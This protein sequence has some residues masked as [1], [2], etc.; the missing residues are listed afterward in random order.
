MVGNLLRAILYLFNQI[1]QLGRITVSQPA[2]KQASKTAGRPAGRPA[3]RRPIIGRLWQTRFGI[4]CP[5]SISS[6]YHLARSCS[7][8]GFGELVYSGDALCAAFIPALYIL[9]EKL[10][11]H[12]CVLRKTTSCLLPFA[13]PGKI[14][15]A[16]RFVPQLYEG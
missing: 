12:V 6:C 15:I 16:R 13:T 5:H 9:A 1:K 4:P 2:S 7:P 8:P 14:S 10:R 11:I 3:G